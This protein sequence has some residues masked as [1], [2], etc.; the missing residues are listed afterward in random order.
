MTKIKGMFYGLCALIIASMTSTP[1]IAGSAEFAG[2]YIALSGS[3][4]GIELDGESSDSN[5]DVHNG[6]AG[7]FGFAG[8]A[9]A[10]WSIPISD[11]FFVS[12]G[13]SYMPGDIQLDVDT[14]DAASAADVT[15]QFDDA[16]SYF[17]MPSVSVTDS[18]AVFL[19][20]GRTEVDMTVTGDVTKINDVSGDFLAIGTRSLYGSGLF[21][22]TEA[23]VT[24]WDS[25]KFTGLGNNINTTSTATADPTS[26]Y[27]ALTIG[28]RF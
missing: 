2:P 6:D 19:K 1:S 13:A 27:G 20:G 4:N 3:V 12:I 11:S 14:G 10:G 21:I 28:F 26:A 5:S 22:Q 25:M 17:I 18:A 7:L 15:I 24:K 23:G 16:W 9:E 8:G